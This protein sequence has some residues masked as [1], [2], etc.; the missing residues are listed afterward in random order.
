M[1]ELGLDSVALD[2][3]TIQQADAVVIITGHNAVDYE[4]VVTEAS[5]V[6]DLRN[7]TGRRGLE[8]DNVSR[9]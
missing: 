8:G 6:L 3:A 1:P 9:L 5:S 7:A 2:A 4:L